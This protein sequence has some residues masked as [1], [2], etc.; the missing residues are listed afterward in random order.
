ML[1]HYDKCHNQEPNIDLNKQ[2]NFESTVTSTSSNTVGN[3]LTNIMRITGDM[4]AQIKCVSYRSQHLNTQ[5]K[6]Y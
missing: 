2:E 5:H 1:V 6:H 4:N 3:K